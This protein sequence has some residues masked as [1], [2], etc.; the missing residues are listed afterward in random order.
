M[1]RADF[2]KEASARFSRQDFE[3]TIDSSIANPVTEAHILKNIKAS[4]GGVTCLLPPR[5]G[6]FE[7]PMRSPIDWQENPPDQVYAEQFLLSDALFLDSVFQRLY[8]GSPS[9]RAMLTHSPQVSE[10]K[11]SLFEEKAILGEYVFHRREIE[12]SRELQHNKD[13]KI[14]PLVV[15]AHEYRH[16]F[17]EYMKSAFALDVPIELPYFFA[18]SLAAELDAHCF[19]LI[20]AY[21]VTQH[22]GMTNTAFQNVLMKDS[23]HLELDTG[24]IGAFTSASQGDYQTGAFYH[25]MLQAFLSSPDG[26]A[27]RYARQYSELHLALSG[28]TLG[29]AAICLTNPRFHSQSTNYGRIDSDGNF[30][31]TNASSSQRNNQA[32]VKDSLKRMAQMPY[33]QS[34]NCLVPRSLYMMGITITPFLSALTP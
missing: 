28:T 25:A 31:I 4:W 7:L 8:C 20:C 14:A 19:A 22:E 9:F 15:V 23:T 12:L 5:I 13:L 34:D 11:S 24:L 32:I 16:R 30:V 26:M 17:Q 10:T 21:E 2:L 1:G 6:I 29:N 18:L 27:L 33:S 3:G